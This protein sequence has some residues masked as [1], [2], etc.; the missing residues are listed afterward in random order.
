VNSE[1][2]L[3]A[4]I[5]LLKRRKQAV[6]QVFA[7]ISIVKPEVAQGTGLYIFI[8]VKNLCHDSTPIMLF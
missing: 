7:Y 1:Q 2:S 4:F 6:K 5:V 3:L 8:T